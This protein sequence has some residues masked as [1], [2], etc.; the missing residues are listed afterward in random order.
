MDIDNL[1]RSTPHDGV[2]KFGREILIFLN[3]KRRHL[4]DSKSNAEIED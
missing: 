2:D 3:I 1:K 4:N